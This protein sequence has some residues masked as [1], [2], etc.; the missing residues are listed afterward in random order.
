[1]VSRGTNSCN[2]IETKDYLVTHESFFVE[3]KEKGISFTR[4]VIA[5]EEIDKY[6]NTADYLSHSSN[7]TLMSFFF[8]FFSKIM[9]KKK[10]SFMLGLG[11]V[12]TY[13]DYGC[14]VGKLISSMNKKEVASYG[15]DTSSLAISICNNKSLNASSNLDDLPNQY[16]LI[17]FWHSLEH[18]SDYTK[19]L[20]KTKQMLSNNGTVVVALPNYDSFDAKFYSKF[21]AAYDTPRHRVHFTKKG[22]IKAA[23]QLGFDVVKTKPLFLDSFYISMMSEKYKQSLFYF[24]KGFFIG[25]FSN[26][27]FFFTKQASSHVYVLKNL[28]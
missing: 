2:S 19:V 21:W 13:L 7:K 16:N 11:G 6:Y 20:K 27:C 23:S 22:F 24:L 25:A 12:N 28:K 18:V 9:V 4:P 10:T 17:S 15:Y 14:G 3:E 26:L 5:D 1:M 8:D